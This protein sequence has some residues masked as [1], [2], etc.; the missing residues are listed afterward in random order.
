MR[1]FDS[2]TGTTAED[3]ENL[4]GDKRAK[5]ATLTIRLTDELKARIDRASE[6]MPYRPTITAIAERGFELAL[7][8]LEEFVA[9][10]RKDV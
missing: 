1:W 9:A 6:T 10:F 2:F 5:G 7:K 8:E 3:R 4:M